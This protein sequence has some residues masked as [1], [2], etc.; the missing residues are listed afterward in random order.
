MAKYKLVTKGL[1]E[2]TMHF[3]TTTEDNRTIENRCSDSAYAIAYAMT[4]V[5]SEL[6]EY[7]KQMDILTDQIENMFSHSVSMLAPP[8]KQAKKK[9]KNHSL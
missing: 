5:A 6:A 8:I 4:A 3:R 2:P 1:E 9:I 7:N